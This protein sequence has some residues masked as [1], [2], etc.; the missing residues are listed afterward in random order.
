MHLLKLIFMEAKIKCWLY[1]N[2]T[3]FI[4]IHDIMQYLATDSWTLV[5]FKW[6]TVTN[7]NSAYHVKAK[8]E[9]SQLLSYL[10]LP[11]SSPRPLPCQVY[12]ESCWLP[13]STWKSSQPVKCLKV[14]RQ[15]GLLLGRVVSL[16][17]CA[18]YATLFI[19]KLQ[20]MSCTPLVTNWFGP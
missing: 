2:R 20:V 7:S 14:Y 3:F 15:A 12:Q 5:S 19:R 10:S 18:W 13:V 11:K 4:R 6:F 9:V 1:K 16:Y 17:I 8:V